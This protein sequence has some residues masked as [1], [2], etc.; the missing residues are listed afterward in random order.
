MIFIENIPHVWLFD[1]PVPAARLVEGQSTREGLV[2]VYYNKTW[3]WVCADKWD[4]QEADV[5]CRMMGF[6]GSLSSFS[7]KETKKKKTNL[8]VWLNNMQCFGNESS[9]FSCIYSS[10][11][12]HVCD[13]RGKAG[14]IC[15]SKGKNISLLVKK[16]WKKMLSASRSL[17]M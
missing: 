10:L 4:K 14:A 11:G 12:D 3:G 13:S 17:T 5:A 6:P 8:R 7:D 16:K 15:R 9:L 2:Q 1:C